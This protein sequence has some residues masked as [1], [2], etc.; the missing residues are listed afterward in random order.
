MASAAPT[1]LQPNDFAWGQALHPISVGEPFYQLNVPQAVLLQSAWTDLRD[2]R[3]FNSLGEELPYA[4]VA[5][6][7]KSQIAQAQVHPYVLTP[8]KLKPGA[9]V[10]KN[11]V[12]EVDA[13][14]QIRVEQNSSDEASG[15]GAE[16]IFKLPDLPATASLQ[17]IRFNWADAGQNW[18]QFVNV[19]VSGQAGDEYGREVFMHQ[20]LMDLKSGQEHLLVQDVGTATTTFSLAD[21]HFLKVTFAPGFAPKLNSIQVAIA[22]Q[23]PAVS[24]AE[25]MQF[26]FVAKA[27]A[28]N[29]EV[30]YQLPHAVPL[31]TLQVQL[32]QA[33]SVARLQLDIRSSSQE[34]WQ[35]LPPAVVYRLASSDRA[36]ALDVGLQLVQEVRIQPIGAGW[37]SGQPQVVGNAP[38]T[39]LV[40]NARGPAPYL[41]AWGSKAV[42]SQAL[43]LDK[44]LPSGPSALTLDGIAMVPLAD[45]VQTLGGPARLTELSLAER[46]SLQQKSLLWAVLLA[47]AAALA[48]LAWRVWKEMQ[49]PADTPP[50]QP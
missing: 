13:H 25:T 27:S 19:Q 2:V 23:A 18:Q 29:R 42:G 16:Y 48:Y 26:D 24:P 36:S 15:E 9:V 12:V 50:E 5:N 17:K 44:L 38:M 31:Q 14:G 49:H 30:I 20:P 45:K 34:A 32:P 41:L 8:F 39:T 47:G 37:G 6:T 43:P 7:H 40:F 11:A 46:S 35:P 21:S 1:V 3:V 28:T 33:N 10:H 4:L 22:S